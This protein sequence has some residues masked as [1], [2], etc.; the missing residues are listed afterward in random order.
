MAR[1]SSLVGRARTGFV[2]AGESFDI[3][4]GA[5]DGLRCKR[6]VHEEREQAAITGTQTIKRTVTL[7]LSNLAG[8]ARAAE[9]TER[10]P[11]S[12]IEGLEIKLTDAAGWQP[13]P[14]DGY[15]KRQVSVQPRAND[16]LIFKYEI[17]AARNVQLLL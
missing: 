2:G 8:E 13:D 9:L 17:K 3:G 1:G 11:V 10:V 16:S 6:N 4:F 5:D 7:Y 14:K 15:L 12:E